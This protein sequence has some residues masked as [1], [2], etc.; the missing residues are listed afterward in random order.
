MGRSEQDKKGEVI[1]HVYRGV[2]ISL[3]ILQMAN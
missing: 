1:C 3:G 2:P